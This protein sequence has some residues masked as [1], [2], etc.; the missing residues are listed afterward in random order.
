[1]FQVN[2]WGYNPYRNL[3]NINEIPAELITDMSFAKYKTHG[4][5]QGKSE[6]QKEWERR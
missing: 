5:Y 6:Q 1:M 2:R 4:T 3:H